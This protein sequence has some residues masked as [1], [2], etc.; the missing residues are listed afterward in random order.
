ME[1]F[2]LIVRLAGRNLRR[3]LRRSLLT[4][5]AVVLGVGLLMFVRAWEAGAHVMYVESATRMG[6]GHVAMEH[7]A[8][9]GS[10]ELEDRIPAST[11]ARIR[12]AVA[13]A[14]DPA[15]LLAVL[16]RI[17]VGGLGQSASSSIPLQVSGVDPG[18]EAPVSFFVDK[19]EAGRYLE[20]GDRLEAVVGAG[21]A[22]RLRLE[23]GSRLVLMVQG[24]DGELESQLV[25]VEGIFR[26]GIPEVDRGVVHLPL[27]TAQGWLGME[28]DVTSVNVV[29]ASDRHT[30]PVARAVR[31]ALAEDG[32]GED[33]VAVRPWWE[34]MPDL[35]AG[36]R[37]DAVQTYIM[38]LVLLGIVGL[39]VVNSVLMAVL[40]RTREFG[41]LR[42]LGLNRR[43]VV[44][45]VMVEGTLLTLVSGILG[46]G[47]G[48]LISLGVFRNGLDIS[49][50]LSEGDLAF[51][52][53]VIDPVILPVVQR[54]DVLAIFAIVVTIGILASIYP[55]WQASR[56][57]PDEAMK[58]EN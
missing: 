5:S 43:S 22:Q 18:A 4:A 12:E 36:L 9:M 33:Q 41:V 13:G 10:R 25:R 50:L 31:S 3:Q 58:S 37:A 8:F 54:V 15:A 39:A 52:G 14:A 11:L 32:V 1:R 48:L 27:A 53:A 35:H 29:L 49:V 38:L 7:P 6:T 19:V 40:Y 21:V 23:L 20:P 2:L 46:M 51:G 26:T 30:D 16:P 57:A 42:A 34:A 56:I 55:A 17:T 44:G 45:M 28:E 24:V 47:L